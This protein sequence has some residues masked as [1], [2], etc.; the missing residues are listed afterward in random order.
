[1][2]P[3]DEETPHEMAYHSIEE[4][5]ELYYIDSGATGHYIDNVHALHDYVPFEVP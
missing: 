4:V 1:V 3:L 5:G 2:Q